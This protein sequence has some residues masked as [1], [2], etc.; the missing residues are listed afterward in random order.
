NVFFLSRFE[1]ATSP[2]RKD[3]LS[4]RADTLFPLLSN[5]LNTPPSYVLCLGDL[6]CSRLIGDFDRSRLILEKTLVLGL[7]ERL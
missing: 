2:L 5:L 6:D 1:A 3:V 7:R 4:E